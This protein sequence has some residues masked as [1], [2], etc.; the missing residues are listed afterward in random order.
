MHET[1]ELWQKFFDF[2]G[3]VSDF[4]D[5]RQLLDECQALGFMHFPTLPKT[6]NPSHDCRSRQPSPAST[7]DDDFI[8][9]QTSRLIGRVDINAQQRH[10][11]F[12][13]CHYFS[14]TSVSHMMLP[15]IGYKPMIFLILS[16]IRPMKLLV[17]EVAVSS[18]SGRIVF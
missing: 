14:S 4:N 11:L 5:H 13:I 17:S 1:V 9:W 15:S 16:T 8:Q 3:L 18:R 10:I 2:V 12:G 7:L 6:H